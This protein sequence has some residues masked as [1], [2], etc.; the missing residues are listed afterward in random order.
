MK[1]TPGQKSF[2]VFFLRGVEF[3]KIKD[4]SMFGNRF[5]FI[6]FKK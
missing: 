5:I 6:F 4:G 3:L 1:T 2:F